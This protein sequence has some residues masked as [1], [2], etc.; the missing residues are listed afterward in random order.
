MCCSAA[1]QAPEAKKQQQQQQKHHTDALNLRA[2]NL[3][4]TSMNQDG[5]GE[6]IWMG[7]ICVCYNYHLT[8][9]LQGLP[10][11]TKIKKKEIM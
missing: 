6:R 3:K 4:F 1:K 9:S 10:Q 11:P 2:G 8:D 5:K 7:R